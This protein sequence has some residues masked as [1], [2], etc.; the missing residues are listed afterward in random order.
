MVK[1][2]AFLLSTLIT[3]CSVNAAPP[4]TTTCT[5]CNNN[6]EL[7]P[8]MIHADHHNAEPSKAIHHSTDEQTTLDACRRD[9]TWKSVDYDECQ[10]L[11]GWKPRDQWWRHDPEGSAPWV[12]DSQREQVSECMTTSFEKAKEIH[13]WARQV[14]YMGAA[15]LLVLLYGFVTEI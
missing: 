14:Y 12:D 1:G 15:R 7:D 8:T 3:L 2:S 5:Q 4:D 6:D 11:T 13:E 9:P 10:K